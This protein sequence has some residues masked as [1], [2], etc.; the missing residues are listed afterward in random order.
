MDY[1]SWGR[2]ARTDGR[3]EMPLF[4]EDGPEELGRFIVD[5]EADSTA[6]V[7]GVE[8]RTEFHRDRGATATLPDGTVYQATGD[9]ARGKEI[10]VRLA[11]RRFTLINEK[12]NDWIVDDADSRKVA[13]FSGGARG[14]RRS[15]LEFDAEEGAAELTRSE[16]AALSWFARLLLEARLGSSSKTLILV[17]ALASVVAILAFL[18]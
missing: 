2:R 17:L 9:F 14:V 10:E 16:T 3:T 13:Q 11:D 12:S 6:L 7:D 8:W 4:V 15:I 5:D 1:T 18:F